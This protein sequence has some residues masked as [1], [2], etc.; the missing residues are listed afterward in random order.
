MKNFLRKKEENL[1]NIQAETLREN[2]IT[3]S[4]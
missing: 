4:P 2:G 3:F 1:Q